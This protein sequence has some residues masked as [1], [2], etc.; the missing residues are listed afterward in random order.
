MTPHFGRARRERLDDWKARLYASSDQSASPNNASVRRRGTPVAV[1]AIRNKTPRQVRSDVNAFSARYVEDWD[2]WLGAH[3]DARPQLFGRILRKWQA[4]RPVAMRRLRA[5]AKHRPPFLDDLLESAAEPLRALAGLTVLTIAHRTREQDQALTTL[6]T[7]FSRLP[8]SGAAS[9]VGISKAVLLLTDGRIG[10][11][12]DSQVRSKLGV[13]RPATCRSHSLAAGVRR[14]EGSVECRHVLKVTTAAL[15]C[16]PFAVSLSAA[17]GYLWIREQASR[18]SL[19]MR[20]PPPTGYERISSNDWSFASWLRGLPLRGSGT[21]VRLFDGREKTYQGGAFG[22][23]DIDVGSKDLQQ[24]ADAVIRL[25]AEYL[26]AAGCA[27]RVSFDFTSG[28]PA[29]WLDWR[30]GRR[31]VVSGN[32]VSWVLQGEPD[33]SYSSFR[34]FLNSVFTYAGSY[35][36]ARELRT[37][38]D[39]A[40]VLP[41]DVLIQGGFPGHAVLV[42]DVAE[43]A[44]GRR[45]FLLVQ[46][47]MPAQDIHVLVN[48]ANRGSPWFPALTEGNLVTPEWTFSYADLRRF[49]E[50]DC[51]VRKPDVESPNNAIQR[52]GRAAPRR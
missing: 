8:T 22:V 31:P 41:G 36:L 26:L 6:W 5:E 29:R 49:A 9:C 18:G 27:D 32:K 3:R 44:K 23:V 24:C 13:G 7:I 25:R 35:S 10:P 16:L 33:S 28:H 51:D 4:T 17:P 47:Y 48:P 42:A 39:P 14:T 11:A 15:V 52:P 43:D 19:A 20:L 46:S 45:V 40:A 34:N 12:F 2:A 38:A 21:P 1:E 50:P 30:A 37:V